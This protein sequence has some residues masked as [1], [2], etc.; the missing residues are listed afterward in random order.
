M[1]GHAIATALYAAFMVWAAIP[2]T[3]ILLRKLPGTVSFNGQLLPA[4]SVE[5]NQLCFR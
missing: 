2:F 3:Y 1:A 5:D 4:Y